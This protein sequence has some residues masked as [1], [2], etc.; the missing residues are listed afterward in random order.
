[1]HNYQYRITFITTRVDIS[2]SQKDLYR[3]Q[4]LRSLLHLPLKQ[5]FRKTTNHC[6]LKSFLSPFVPPSSTHVDNWLSI[7]R[8]PHDVS[9][10]FPLFLFFSKFSFW[11]HKLNEVN[12]DG[13]AIAVVV[14]FDLLSSP[15]VVRPVT[16]QKVIRSMG[17]SNC[18]RD[19]GELVQIPV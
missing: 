2:G 17:K 8:F 9:L 4:C 14:I 13:A 11:R 12:V 7:V 1:M 5:I 16:P 3:A 6:C 10:S 19:L 15:S 18:L